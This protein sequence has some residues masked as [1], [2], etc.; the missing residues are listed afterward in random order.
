MK[1]IRIL[2][3]YSGDRDVGQ[4]TSLNTALPLRVAVSQLLKSDEQVNS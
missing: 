4:L 2:Q 3:G 1:L